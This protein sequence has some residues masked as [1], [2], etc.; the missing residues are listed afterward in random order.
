MARPRLGPYAPLSASYYDDDAIAQAGEAA[1][2]LFVRGLAF[3]ARMV[4]D[5][6]ISD[7]QV[8]RTVGVGMRD[9]HRRADRLVEVGLWERVPG[10][11][12]VRSWLKWNRSAED[13]GRVK[14]KDR[15][16]KAQVRG[17]EGG[18][19]PP[20]DG[21]VS[22]RSPS[23]IQTDS[24][25]IP[26][27]TSPESLYPR[28]RAGTSTDPQH[29]SN[30]EPPPSGS[31]PRKRGAR[32]DPAWEPSQVQIDFAL[33]LGLNP[34]HVAATFRDYWISKPGRDG[35]KADWV[36]TWRNWCR[37]EA[38][39]QPQA[40]ASTTDQ[41]V[42]AGLDLAAKFAAQEAATPQLRMIPGRTA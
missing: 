28:A 22:E 38:E 23:G 3:C 9:A 15:E 4:S 42:Q 30:T 34:Q 12:V 35:V 16:R 5:G 36:A 39:R 37:R 29:I 17:S 33:H 40:K 19:V 25:R 2:L 11:Y 6:F 32:L 14:Q 26:T 18:L 27:D 13:I 20:D 10:G 7:A 24:E 8:A 31:P 21:P 41:R 1:E